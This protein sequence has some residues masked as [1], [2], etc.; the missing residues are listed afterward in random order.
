M[1]NVLCALLSS[2]CF[3]NE[4]GSQKKRNK[5]AFDRQKNYKMKNTRECVCV[6]RLC[7]CDGFA[8]CQMDAYDCHQLA[9]NG[10]FE[11]I[12]FLLLSLLLSMWF[13]VRNDHPKYWTLND[14]HSHLRLTWKQSSEKHSKRKYRRTL[15]TLQVGPAKI[16]VN[17]SVSIQ[18]C[19]NIWRSNIIKWG[20]LAGYAG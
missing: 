5:N 1:Q 4:N 8:S 9:K 6:L 19:S 10:T 14:H 17:A 13:I 12:F 18:M 20:H 2:S 16:V 7:V 3:A 15:H 11:R